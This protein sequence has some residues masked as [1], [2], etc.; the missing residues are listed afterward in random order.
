MV[1]EHAQDVQ[2]KMMWEV[3][4]CINIP[5]ANGKYNVQFV[6]GEDTFETQGD[7]VVGHNFNRWVQRSDVIDIG[8][9]Y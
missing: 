9:P 2:W 6:I 1:P 4:Q 8:A 7:A 3:D 5:E